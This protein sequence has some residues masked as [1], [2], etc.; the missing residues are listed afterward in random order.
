MSKKTYP[1]F[2]RDPV[3]TA[4]KS[5]QYAAKYNAQFPNEPWPP[6]KSGPQYFSEVLLRDLLKAEA[7]KAFGKV[8][9]D[10]DQLMMLAAAAAVIPIKQ[11]SAS[12]HYVNASNH[13]FN[14]IENDLIPEYTSQILADLHVL[15]IQ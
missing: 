4:K 15:D 2:I 12:E 5:E 13:F 10:G 14:L 1:D 8:V 6:V 7:K 11:N 9:E 3:I